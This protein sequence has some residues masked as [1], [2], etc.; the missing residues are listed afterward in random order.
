LKPRIPSF[1]FFRFLKKNGSSPDLGNQIN[2]L[3]G[4]WGY[5]KRKLLAKGG[6]RREKVPLFLGEYVWR[7]NIEPIRKGLKLN[8]S[9]NC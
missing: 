9:F 2:G 7:Y 4:F 1:A 5:L 3:E 8:D 6:I